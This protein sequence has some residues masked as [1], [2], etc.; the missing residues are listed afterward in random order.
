MFFRS[1]ASLRGA[2]T[3]IALLITSIL[4][5]SARPASAESDQPDTLAGAQAAS[6]ERMGRWLPGSLA[7]DRDRDWFG[8]RLPVASTVLITLG[9]V[10]A[11]YRLALFGS[12]GR[13]IASAD[14]AG[15]GYEQVHT[16]LAAGRYFVEVSSARGEFGPGRGYRLLVRPIPNRVFVLDAHPGR[17]GGLVTVTGQLLNNTGSWRRYPKVTARFFG[18]TGAYLGQSTALAEQSYLSPGQRGHFRIV[19]DAPPGMIRYTLSVRAARTAPPARA[20][21]RLQADE[22]YRVDGRTRY[23]GRVTAAGTASASR[24]HVHVL[25][26]NR[27][28]AFIDYDHAVL[29]RVAPGVPAR[30]QLELP[31]L[32]YV[33]AVRLDYSID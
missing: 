22:P 1:L 11:D 28:G 31:T 10:P 15:V 4:A 17:Q 20:A 7:S 14:R 33:S 26:Y 13:P 19:A 12:N 24:V 29:P 23:V 27:I 2:A 32:G 5:T 25:R 8:F 16:R 9:D 30:Y 21:L 3:V 18:A 6:V